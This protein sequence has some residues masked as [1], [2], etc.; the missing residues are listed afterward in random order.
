MNRLRDHGRAIWTLGAVAAAAAL[1]GMTGCD[2]GP[3]PD[4]ERGQQLFTQKC[5]S[6]HAL[7]GAGTSAEVG[8]CPS[9]LLKQA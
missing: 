9:F 7:T 4:L 8:A 6:C 1:V 5:G 3:E 2:L